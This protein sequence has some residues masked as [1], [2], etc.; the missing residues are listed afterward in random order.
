MDGLDLS[1]VHLLPLWPRVASRSLHGQIFFGKQR[2][3]RE[4]IQSHCW[5]HGSSL[6]PKGEMVRLDHSEKTREC[7]VASPSRNPWNRINDN[8]DSF[9]ELNLCV[10][11]G[12]DR[13]FFA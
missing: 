13:Q 6:A 4:K 12:H 11:I 5:L 8:D 7:L 3:M 10:A 1:S 9:H 2:D